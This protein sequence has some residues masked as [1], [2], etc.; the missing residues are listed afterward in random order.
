MSVA[1]A[2][3]SQEG[4]ERFTSVLRL[5][6]DTGHLEYSNWVLST[7]KTLPPPLKRKSGLSALFSRGPQKS[8][9]CHLHSLLNAQLVDELY[10]LLADEC[11]GRMQ[12]LTV[13]TSLLPAKEQVRI[14]HVQEWHQICM[15]PDLYLNSRQ[16]EAGS[17]PFLQ[18]SKCP[19]CCIVRLAARPSFLIDLLVVTQSRHD[20]RTA[21][22]IPFLNSFLSFH[23]KSLDSQVFMKIFAAVQEE[24]AALQAYRRKLHRMRIECGSNEDEAFQATAASEARGSASSFTPTSAR[25]ET[26]AEPYDSILS[27]VNMYDSLRSSLLPSLDHAV[28]S[29]KADPFLLNASSPKP[30]RSLFVRVYAL[31][32]V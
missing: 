13:N 7:I 3:L 22:V 30:P 32:G 5:L 25:V 31:Q 8:C 29:K 4:I 14:K 17:Q 26:E 9:L 11:T 6:P 21:T 19:A 10:N 1:L 27:I 24:T 18:T 20:H 2:N 23:T 12:N 15:H 28:L 16:L